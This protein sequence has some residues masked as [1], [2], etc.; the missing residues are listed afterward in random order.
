MGLTN[1]SQ[2]YSH[3]ATT[4]YEVNGT[5]VNG[6]PFN[7]NGTAYNLNGYHAILQAN[8]PA[9]TGGAYSLI[10]QYKTLIYYNDILI[11]DTG[12]QKRIDM[13]NSNYN[14]SSFN[15]QRGPRTW[16]PAS[17]GYYDS[18][19]KYN[20]IDIDL[21]VEEDAETS[22]LNGARARK[23]SYLF[24]SIYQESVSNS[25]ISNIEN[26]VEAGSHFFLGDLKADISLYN[27]QS[28]DEE[29]HPPYGTKDW[30]FTRNWYYE[31]IKTSNPPSFYRNAIVLEDGSGEFGGNS[32]LG[33]FTQSDYND[34]C[35]VVKVGDG[36]FTGTV[37]QNNVSPTST[38]YNIN[39]T[40]SNFGKFSGHTFIVNTAGNFT[41]QSRSRNSNTNKLLLWKDSTNN[42]T[43]TQGGN[44]FNSQL[45]YRE[46][47]QTAY[48][49][50]GTY[51]VAST[52]NNNVNTGARIHVHHIDTNHYPNIFG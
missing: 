13:G 49:S 11:H 51:Q 1:Q 17:G 41:F 25:H 36:F 31:V 52:T 48:L 20:E 10:P 30:P 9:Y 8:F 40:S 22:Y 38:S 14:G 5:A 34:G 50:V 37:K 43:I 18:S 15:T 33:Y 7:G 3:G 42:V 4:V 32:Q 21:D 46:T 24:P 45:A 19:T 47:E 28:Y 39:G 26:S 2:L 27:W 29:N 6:S 35:Y 12:Y 44:L 23:Y 16:P